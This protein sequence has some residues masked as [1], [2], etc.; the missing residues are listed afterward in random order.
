M[1]YSVETI[2]SVLNTKTSD[3]LIEMREGRCATAMDLLESSRDWI[4]RYEYRYA[5]RDPAGFAKAIRAHR[6]AARKFR[7]KCKFG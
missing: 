5:D 3:A 1:A 6:A 2:L 7:T 4:A